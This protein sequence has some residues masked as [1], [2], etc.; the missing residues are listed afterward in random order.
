MSDMDGMGQ[1]G[2]YFI[3][4]FWSD[5]FSNNYMGL[6]SFQ[7]CGVLSDLFTEKV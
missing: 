2:C 1:T 3:R 7:L 5:A 6:H 4:Y